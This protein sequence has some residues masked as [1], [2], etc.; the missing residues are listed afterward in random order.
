MRLTAIG[1]ALG[2]IGALALGR[3]LGSLLFGVGARDVSAFLVVLPV[4][5]G[6]ALLASYLPARRSARVNPVVAL[7]D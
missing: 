7:R 5:G 6:A 3:A 4:M 1:V 2:A